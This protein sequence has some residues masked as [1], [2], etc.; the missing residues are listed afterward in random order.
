MRLKNEESPSLKVA[1]VEKI[2]FPAIFHFDFSETKVLED[3]FSILW[4][5]TINSHFT[6]H[7]KPHEK[8]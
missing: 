4:Y 2:F 7:E 8:V 5:F 1:D 3:S 6:H